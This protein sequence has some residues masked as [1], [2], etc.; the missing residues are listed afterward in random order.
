MN[1]KKILFG[2]K[3]PMSKLWASIMWFAGAWLM[4]FSV[5]YILYVVIGFTQMELLW[6]LVG[7]FFGLALFVVGVIDFCYRTYEE[8]K[9][10]K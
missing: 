3:K 8:S 2:E 6:A 1:R 5:G 9:E 7:I 10:E 4:M